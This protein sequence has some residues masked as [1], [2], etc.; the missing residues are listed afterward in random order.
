V[1]RSRRRSQ[2][3]VLVVLTLA[4]LPACGAIHDN[5]RPVCRYGSPAVLMAQSVRD[6]SLI[7]CVGALPAGWHFHG[8]D[9]ARGLSQFWLD[10]DVLGRRALEVVLTR[11]C[12]TAGAHRMRSDEP[13]TSRYERIDRRRPAFSGEWL[14]RFAGGCVRYVFAFSR[15]APARSLRQLEGGLSFIRRERIARTFQARVGPTLDPPTDGR[16]GQVGGP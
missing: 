3:I 8:F 9:A 12:S 15:P 1:T 16:L 2:T 10:S 5:T 13:H 14:Y 6:A 7:P 4:V 11:S